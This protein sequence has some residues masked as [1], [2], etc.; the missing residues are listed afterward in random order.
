MIT[1]PSACIQ[2]EEGSVAKAVLMP[3]DPLRAKYVAEH[4]LEDPVLFNSVRNMYGYT[5]TYKGKKISV[6]GSG[7]GIPSIGLYAYDLYSFLWSRGNHPDRIHR[8]DQ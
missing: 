4:Y 3:G 7:M 1:T 5:G 8:S 6:M 2:A